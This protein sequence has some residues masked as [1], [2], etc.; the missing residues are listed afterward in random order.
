MTDEIKVFGYV[1]WE[2]LNIVKENFPSK[3]E[4]YE[5]RLE[6]C[7]PIY[8]PIPISESIRRQISCIEAR[9]E[10]KTMFGKDEIEDLLATLSACQ[11]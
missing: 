5:E 4:I 6:M 11:Q 9:K 2:V 7:M 3:V 10:E 1:V 8:K